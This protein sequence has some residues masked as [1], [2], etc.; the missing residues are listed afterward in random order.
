MRRKEEIAEAKREAKR[1]ENE[2]RQ[3]R[4]LEARQ[5][6]EASKE[7]SRLQQEKEQKVREIMSRAFRPWGYSP[8]VSQAKESFKLNLQMEILTHLIYWQN[9][10]FE[11]I[12]GNFYIRFA[13]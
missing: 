8:L 11:Q 4:V 6:Q 2:A 3:K 1:K 5:K 10:Q 9:C 13:V 7:K 12:K